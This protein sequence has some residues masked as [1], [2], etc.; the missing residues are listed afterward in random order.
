MAANSGFTDTGCICPCIQQ[1]LNNVVGKN[2]PSLRRDRVGLLEYLMST[3]N[4]S[5]TEKIQVDPGN[6]KRKCVTLNWYQK[7]CES[8]VNE[9]ITDDCSTGNESEPFCEDIEADKELE[10]NNLIFDEDDMRRLCAPLG[11]TDEMWIASVIMAQMN[12]ILIKLDKLALAQ[13]LANV[14][15]FMDGSTIKDIQLFNTLA[16]NAQG[17]RTFAATNIQ[18]EFDEAA[19]FGTP[20]IIGHGDV[21]KYFHAL[22]YGCCNAVG[23]D[24]GNVKSDLSL[25]YD[26][27]VQGVFG[28][29]EFIVLAP[30]MVHLLTWNKYV[31]NY[32]K[33]TPSFEHGTI[34]DPFSGIRFDLKMHYDDCTDRYY[35]KLQL[36][37]NLFTVPSEADAS[38]DDHFGVN[39]IFN[40]KVCDALTECA[41]AS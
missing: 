31:G 18:N 7:L 13:V 29:D 12:A 3:A 1:A 26:R 27:F 39:G 22:G 19:L 40:F 2:A 16:T 32:A 30:G 35:T 8:T 38:C 25:Y 10:T 28:A 23:Q 37:W 6:G 24:V 17:P 21:N 20:A 11:T 34:V 33:K 4:T 36:Y 41:D 15:T 9:S 14:G 5:G